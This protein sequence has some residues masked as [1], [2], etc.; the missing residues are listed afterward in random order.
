MLNYV[1]SFFSALNRNSHPGDIA[2]A[3]ALGFLL[4]IMPKNNLLWPAVFAF[5]IFLRINKGAFFLSFIFLGFLTPFMDVLIDRLGFWFLS[6]PALHGFYAT[7]DTIPFVG[8]TKFYN[9]MVTGGLIL[10]LILY[11]PVY[12]LVRFLVKL[13]RTKALPTVRY[14]K[15]DSKAAGFLSRLPVLRHLEKIFKI[16]DLFDR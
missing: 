13:Y 11:V 4:A 15:E 3:V 16:K 9:T 1:H 14:T 8:L 5:S 6:L 12:F 7:L 2:H 10:G